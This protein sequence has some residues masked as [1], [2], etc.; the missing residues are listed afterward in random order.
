MILLPNPY[1]AT[2][3]AGSETAGVEIV[4]INLMEQDAPHVNM[5]AQ[6]GDAVTDFSRDTLVI[7]SARRNVRAEQSLVIRAVETSPGVYALVTDGIF[8]APVSGTDGPLVVGALLHGNELL[9]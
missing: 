9:V 4:L 2:Y 3:A 7:W 5:T 8:T 6:V 1:Y